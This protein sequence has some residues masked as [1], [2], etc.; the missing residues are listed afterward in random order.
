MA[1][2]S[3]ATNLV[4][5]A[6]NRFAQIYR[7]DLQSGTTVLLSANPI[8]VLMPAM[9]DNESSAPAISV[10][11]RFVTYLSSAAN[12]AGGTGG[13]YQFDASTGTNRHVLSSSTNVVPSMSLDGRFIAYG[14]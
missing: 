7:R 3:T 11:G 10:D 4:S 1:F 9:G 8:F 12:L 14:A 5:M 6:A 2:V 13:V